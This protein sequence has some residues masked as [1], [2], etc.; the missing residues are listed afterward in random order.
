[1]E[2]LQIDQEIARELQELEAG[3]V[4]DLDEIL[5]DLDEDEGDEDDEEAC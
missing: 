2:G 4:G 1:M 3:D 5:G